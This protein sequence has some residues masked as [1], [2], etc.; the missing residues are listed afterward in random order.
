MRK[1]RQMRIKM[2]LIERFLERTEFESYEDFLANYKLKIPDNFDFAR[3]VVDQWA[4]LEPSKLALIYCNDD[5]EEVSFTFKQISDLSKRAASYFLSLGI[6]AGDRVITMLRRR[7]EYWVCAVALHRIGAVVVPISIQMET[8]DIVYRANSCCAKMAIIVKDNFVLQQLGNALKDCNTINKVITAGSEKCAEYPYFNEE[9]TKVEPL[10]TYSNLSNEDQMLIYFTSGTSGYPKQAIHNRLYPLGHIIT[11]K[12]L[13][14]VE[15]NGLHITQADS[16]WAKFG[17]GNIYGQ[18]LCGTAI[19][20]YDPEKFCTKNFTNA[21]KTYKPITMCVPPTI[22]RMMLRDGFNKEDVASVRCFVSAGES[23]TKEVNQ[24]FFD[25]VGQY[26][27]EGYGQSEGTPI[28][29]NW[30]WLDIKLSS[31]GKISPLYDTFLQN[32]IGEIPNIGE[33]GEIVLIPKDKRIGLLTNYFYEGSYQKVLTNGKYFTGDEAYFDEHGY[34]WYLGRNDD[35]IKSSGYRIGPFE[36][37]SVLNTHPAVKE[38]AIIGLPDE[39]RGQIVCAVV[40]L[41]EQYTKSEE[42]SSELKNYVKSNTAPYKYPRIIK[43]TTSEL[44]KTTS[45]KLMRSKVKTDIMI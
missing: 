19:L 25:I 36:I 32:K 4:V 5:N 15:D 11:A 23:L 12:Y 3:D 42:L 21:L 29:A 10:E 30:K 22:Y 44:P 38:S 33:I 7:W 43:Y 31:M 17:W 13:Q 37:E 6:S 2:K 14:Q 18:W 28:F 8:K 39:L 34:G 24:A 45:G 27:R 41:N 1:K 9:I 20:A 40:V 35:V 26:I 16:G